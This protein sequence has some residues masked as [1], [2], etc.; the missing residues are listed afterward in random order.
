M[1][2]TPNR[3]LSLHAR[4]LLYRNFTLSRMIIQ[5]HSALGAVADH[6]TLPIG[7]TLRDLGPRG[8]RLCRH[9]DLHALIDSLPRLRLWLHTQC[10]QC[11][12]T[13]GFSVGSFGA[14]DAA[15]PLEGSGALSPK[16]VYRECHQEAKAGPTLTWTAGC[17]KDPLDGPMNWPMNVLSDGEPWILGKSSPPLHRRIRLAMHR[18]CAINSG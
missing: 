15:M 3:S 10:C 14:T 13:C 8:H 18:K 17:R 11:L 9:P 2:Y 1:L 5:A 7:L 16:H 12:T 6:M 4:R